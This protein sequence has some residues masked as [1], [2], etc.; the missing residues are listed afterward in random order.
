MSRKASNENT[1]ELLE[2]LGELTFSDESENLDLVKNLV[3]LGYQLQRKEIRRIK[4]YTKAGVPE[5]WI[6]YEIFIKKQMEV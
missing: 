6:I 4:P 5:T 1:I 2:S 3:N